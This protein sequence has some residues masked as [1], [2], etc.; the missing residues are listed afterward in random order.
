MARIPD[1]LEKADYPELQVV[2]RTVLLDGLTAL[3]E[4]ADAVTVIG[5]Q[6][7]Y[8]RSAEVDL[9]VAAFTTDADLGL[10]PDRLRD[11]PLI[12]DAVT[13]AGFVPRPH[14]PGLWVTTRRVGGRP[15]DIGLDLMV[16]ES[17]AGRGSRSAELPPHARIV[18]RRAQGLEA[19]VVD[20]DPMPITSL[21]PAEDPREVIANVAGPAALLISKA[22]KL[23]ERLEAGKPERIVNKDA[24]DVIRLM[25]AIDATDT[26]ARFQRLLADPR[27]G[28]VSATGLRRLREL[29][30]GS[31]TPGT[32]MAAQALAGDRVESLV[33]PIASAYLASLPRTD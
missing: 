24:G 12:E 26:A 27:A 19:T 11:S 7:L 18:G 25:L 29:F 9:S 22:Y 21:N 8:L 17:F 30:A 3:A 16:A 15:V 6:A 32:E 14:Q 31:R 13:G 23:H 33:H 10:D 20:V 28:E 1:G 4:H 2:A 5:A